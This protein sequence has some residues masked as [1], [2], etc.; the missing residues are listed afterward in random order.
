MAEEDLTAIGREYVVVK[1][2]RISVVD[3][4]TLL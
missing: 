2:A 1:Q 4:T 3:G